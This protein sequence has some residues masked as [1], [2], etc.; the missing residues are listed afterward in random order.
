M[1][2]ESVFCQPGNLS[3]HCLN[4]AV[5]SITVKLS[6]LPAVP[7]SPS[8]NSP[9]WKPLVTDGFQGW[10]VKSGLSSS[11]HPTS[12]P[13]HLLASRGIPFT[14][15]LSVWRLVCV[16]R[17]PLAQMEE[18]RRDHVTKMKKMEQEMEQVFE[19]KVKEKLQKLR[20]S[21][22]EVNW[23]FYFICLLSFC[24]LVCLVGRFFVVCVTSGLTFDPALPAAPEASR[25]DEKEPG[26]PAPR[27]GRETPPTGRGESQLGGPAQ[28]SGTAETRRLPVKT[29]TRVV[30]HSGLAL[31]D[32]L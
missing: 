9:R 15:V 23:C 10:P 27:A 20:D 12:C 3:L 2:Q 5:V 28:D 17:S 31:R 19:M 7:L 11:P 8:S 26:G 24:L 32:A 30:I 21:E 14:C 6:F 4:C 18:E 22:A 16:S 1:L 29:P 25:A 13:Y